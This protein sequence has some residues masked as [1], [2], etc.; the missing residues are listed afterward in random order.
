MYIDIPNKFD[1]NEVFIFVSLLIVLTVSVFLPKRFSLTQVVYILVF[2]FYLGVIVDQILAVP[3]Y[4]FYD[5][6]D[7][8]KMDIMDLI[9]YTLIYPLSAYIFYYFADK[10]RKK[11][12]AA[13]F[14]FILGYSAI[15]LGLEWIASKLGVYKYNDWSFMFSGLAYLLIFSINTLVLRLIKK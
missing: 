15:S 1:K 6:M 7:K 9:I 5:I 11:N 2:N 4:D 14:I 13:I 3:P 12:R 8:P 10:L